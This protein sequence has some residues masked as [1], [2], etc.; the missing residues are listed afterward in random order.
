MGCEL[1]KGAGE[2]GSRTVG[3]VFVRPNDLSNWKPFDY[4]AV[5]RSELSLDLLGA[6]FEVRWNAPQ[7]DWS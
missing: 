5:H 6:G 7:D 4:C 2:C 1:E 3:E